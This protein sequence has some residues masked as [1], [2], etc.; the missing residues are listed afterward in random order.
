MN[1]GIYRYEKMF[2]HQ[3]DMLEIFKDI[4]F[5]NGGLFDCLD[6]HI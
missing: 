2:Y 6:Q 5:L 1:H 4:P 3:E